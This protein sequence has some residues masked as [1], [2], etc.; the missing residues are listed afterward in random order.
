M[1]TKMTEVPRQAA[2]REL[3]AAQTELS[4]L[5]ATASPSRLERALERV[6]AARSALALAA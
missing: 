6:E 5:D 1:S 3:S 4:S 2:E